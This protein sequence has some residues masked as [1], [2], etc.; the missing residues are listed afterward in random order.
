MRLAVI[1]GLAA[2]A[3]A[4]VA[5]GGGSS[6]SVKY[7]PTVVAIRHVDLA[8]VTLTYKEVR[9]PPFADQYPAVVATVNGTPV[10]GTQLAVQEVFL[11]ANKRSYTETTA[12]F[13]DPMLQAREAS[14]ASKDPLEAAIDEQ[15]K[16]QAIQRLG[17]LP[18]HDEAA[19]YTRDQEATVEQGL[20]RA[21]PDQRD[22]TIVM[23]KDEG[24]PASDWASSDTIVSFYQAM[25]AEI[26]LT[27]KVC[28]K[29]DAPLPP[30]TPNGFLSLPSTRSDCS[31]FL[32]QQR[33]NADIVTTFGGRT[34][35]V[36]AP[37]APGER[38][39]G[40]GPYVRSR[41]ER[42][43]HVMRSP[44]HDSATKPGTNR[45]H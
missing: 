26:R 11:E 17:L 32:A 20:A 21:T 13:L 18:S 4:L 40:E 37:L 14:I 33:K 38:G 24:F 23:L 9:Q 34:D 39:S 3:M 42:P 22:Q 6:G 41:R 8:G 7:A 29:Y 1:G 15:L 10:T 43:G 12:R 16:E 2:I 36:R 30:T 25:M 5:C 19:Q 35:A 27:T 31:G 28:L 44:A 45:A